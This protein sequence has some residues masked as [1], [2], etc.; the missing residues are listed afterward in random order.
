MLKP[1]IQKCLNKLRARKNNNIEFRYISENP[2]SGD[3]KNPLSF[4]HD[5]LVDTLKEMVLNSPESFTIGLFGDWGSGKSTVIK[6]LEKELKEKDVPLV[7]FDVW[8]HEGD[9]LR[10]T[11]LN[12]LINDLKSKYGAEY[13]KKGFEIDDR[14]LFTKSITEEFQTILKKRMFLH[15]SVIFLFSAFLILPF[16]LF[17]LS[18][19]ILFGWNL[20]DSIDGKIIGS[21]FSISLL[22]LF[23]KYINQFIQVKKET[24]LQDRFKDPHEFE[25]EFKRILKVG[26][27][28]NKLVIAFDNLDRV[29]G[30][31]AIEIMST[32][33]TFLDPIDDEIKNK[34]IV[35]IIPC[36]E[37]A[38]KRHLRKTLNYS[39][40]FR[41]D[42]YHRYAGEYLRK[43]FNTILWIPE[44]YLSELEGLAQK[45]LAE[46][47]IED[48]NNDE[49]SALIV[50]V[51]NK[52]PRQIIQFINILISNYLLIKQRPIEGFSLSE[53]IAKLA[54]YLL[55]IQKFPDIMSLYRS[56]LKYD[57]NTLPTELNEEVYGVRKFSEKRVAEFNDFLMR[58]EHVKIESLDVFFK[59]RRSI[60]ESKLE[61]GVKLVD[62]M[63]NG[64]M[65]YMAEYL[66]Q[67]KDFNNESI[68]K[69]VKNTMEFVDG[70]DVKDKKHELGQ[71]INDKLRK[72]KNPILLA[73]FV[74]GLLY[75]LERK[76]L[77]LEQDVYR[78]IYNELKQNENN[79]GD[80]N[81]H[82]LLRNC[83]DK[84][85]SKVDKE[86][87]KKTISKKHIEY[88][89]SRRENA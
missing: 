38:I 82:L 54:K 75:F 19:K 16:F 13:F 67:N 10:R 84:L 5:A 53:D 39:N 83:Y 68:E 9:A 4:G 25:M 76:E 73:K 27:L 7:L 62:L 31:K 14:N 87:F 72:T 45:K 74:E 22:P 47:R 80:I 71:V 37:I 46:T 2:I 60:Y 21:I 65:S 28:K 42:D 29:N 85:H 41:G 40:D 34:D 44:F 26:F 49:L 23:Y 24:K 51:F 77:E 35:F 56:T 64:D 70:L 69:L 57:L 52:N 3:K 63:A 86:S 81:P 11:F 6:S 43:F 30:E 36:D 66:T 8:K 15:L 12:T 79:I 58:T 32:I 55:L 59:L 89:V 48:F 20:L 1:K 18:M 50:L 61:Y 78:M 33:K 88:F 17:W